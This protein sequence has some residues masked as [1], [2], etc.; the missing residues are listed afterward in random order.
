MRLVIVL[1]EKVFLSLVH[2][3]REVWER[4]GNQDFTECFLAKPSGIKSIS[5]FLNYTNA[6]LLICSQNWTVSWQASLGLWCDILSLLWFSGVKL[7]FNGFRA[8]RSFMPKPCGKMLYIIMNGCGKKRNIVFLSG[9]WLPLSRG[10]LWKRYF[11][12]E[13]V[14][15]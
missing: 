6:W 1:K 12:K 4:V 13:N 2:V 14:H 11:R 15:N 7:L 3:S 8:L 9:T 5:L 10:W